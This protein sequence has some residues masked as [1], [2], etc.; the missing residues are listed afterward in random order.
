M[1]KSLRWFR[2]L[3]WVGV[4][5]NMTFAIPALV[6]PGL[7]NGLLGLP[8]QAIYPWMSNVGMLLIGVSLFYIPAG[9][10]PERWF[11]YSWLTV[12]SRLIAVIF[13]IYLAQ[14]SG[15]PQ[16]F[17]PLL[18][19]DAAMFVLLGLTLQSGL[20]A[21][22]KCSVCNL[23]QW[24][25]GIK[26][27]LKAKLAVKRVRLIV[28]A[29]AIVVVL[30]GY[31]VWDNL[32]RQYPDPV[33][34]AAEEH[35]KYGAIGLSAQ[36][37]IPQYVFEVMPKV[38][39]TIDGGV[40]EWNKLGF[41]YENGQSLPIGL[42]KR[43]IGYPTVEATCSLCHTGQYQKTVADAPVPILA[44]SANTLDLQRFQW[45]MY[46]CAASEHFTA[47]NVLDEI[48]KTRELGL[49][50]SLYYRFAIIPITRLGL[51]HQS[52]LY[53]WQKLRPQQGRGRTDTFNP[54]KITVFGFPDDGTIGTVDLPQIWNQK[55]REGMWLHWDGNNNAIRERNYAAAMAVGATSDSVLQGSF[56]RITDWL[57]TK[58]PVKY[59]FPIDQAVVDAGKPH[60][61]E[62]CSACHDFGKADT[63]QVTTNI[64]QLGT[65]RYR[66]DS[67]TIGL[68]DKFHTFK[69]PPFD[70][71]AYRKTQSYS[72]TP[73][74]GIWARAPYL[75]NG[76][77]PS[78]WALLQK[79]QDRP[80]RFYKGYKVYDPVDVGFVY[81]G[82]EAE[83]EG[84]LMDT[85]LLGNG[86][87]GHEYGT[88]LSDQQK[89]ELIEYMKTL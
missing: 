17:L 42:A 46:D 59:P 50:E 72:N 54:T 38:C 12:I 75:H 63:G 62:N 29:I 20:P 87:G 2:V 7:L 53:S 77:V 70:F 51:K 18:L 79:P 1:N 55:S 66:L 4:F 3:I 30:F 22:G 47:T 83:Q 36:Y 34:T 39:S 68:V 23:Y 33:Y 67:F 9:L 88:D 80:G 10:S 58:A 78:L 41:V 82:A 73:T 65:D 44:G 14:T 57:L 27:A 15:Y 86:N 25:H 31:T 28:S 74:D 45:F 11:T 32:L 48:T 16:T 35:F 52:S 8:A 81:S 24:L 37:R 69:K 43:H 85:T 71:S 56:K 21:A 6:A 61:D 89:R 40:D 26:T 84:W 60:W 13:W 64:Q 49:I 76:S 19:S 5:I